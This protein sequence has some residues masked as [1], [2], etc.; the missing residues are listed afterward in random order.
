MKTFTGENDLVSKHVFEFEGAIAESVL[1]KYPEYAARTVICC[2]VQSGCPVGCSFCGTGRFFIRN[3]TA[4][5]IASQPIQL[6]QRVA[7]ETPVED[8]Q[9]LQIMFMSMG[10]PGLNMG[11]L[12]K[13]IR[14]LH[15]KYPAAQL[16]VSTRAPKVDWEPFL[17]LSEE[18]SEIGLQFSVHEASDAERDKVIPFK[19]K[20]KL[21]EIAKLGEEWARRTG[22]KPYCNYCVNPG[23]DSSSNVDWLRSLFN[24]DI[25][26]FTLSVICEADQTMQEAHDLHED[27]VTSFTDRMI[28]AGYDT[29]IFN[30]AGQD[31][32]GGGCG[33]LWYFQEWLA[34]RSL[35]V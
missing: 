11:E 18:I 5:E 35:K 16:L 6:L 31:D 28:E 20:L 17:K 7:E 14:I 2:S 24:P 10:E 33:Q 22:R 21:T 19:K 29:R 8:I 9:K 15:D 30:P 1:Y 25:F 26:N 13:A 32:I 4:Q 12:I 23:N 34:K 27:K 3:L